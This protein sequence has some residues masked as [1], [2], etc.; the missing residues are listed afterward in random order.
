MGKKTGEILGTEGSGGQGEGADRL[1]WKRSLV[2]V[3][4]AL[5]TRE[6]IIPGPTHMYRVRDLLCHN[7][8]YRGVSC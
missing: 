2:G 4:R 1:R 7:I 5:Q 6:D 3:P 8:S